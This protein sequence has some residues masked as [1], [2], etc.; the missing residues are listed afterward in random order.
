MRRLG[1][2]TLT[3]LMFMPAALVACSALTVVMN[4]KVVVAGNNDTS[5]SR[6]MKLQITPSRDLCLEINSRA[7]EC[8]SL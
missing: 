4:G 3:T 6:E 1:P 7:L 5:F 8:N 2:L